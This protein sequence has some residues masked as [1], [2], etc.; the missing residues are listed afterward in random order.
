MTVVPT[1]EVDGTTYDCLRRPC[2]VTSFD[3]TGAI[4]GAAD[5]PGS[6]PFADITVDPDTGLTDGDPITARIDSAIPAVFAPNY[7]IAICLASVLGDLP[8]AEGCHVF[9]PLIGP[10]VHDY[11]LIA[12]EQFR[13]VGGGPV[14]SCRDDPDGCIIG[15]G[16]ATT[17]A[18]YAPIS[19]APPGR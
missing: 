13:P 8:P 16:T 9:F 11:G 3:R 17:L 12:Y 2:Q 1:L 5:I 19:F 14:V 4:Q 7:S 10:G 6:I 18:G 15:V